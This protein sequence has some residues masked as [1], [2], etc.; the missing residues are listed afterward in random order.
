MG[1]GQGDFK[2]Q[3]QEGCHIQVAC[4]NPHMHPSQLCSVARAGKKEAEA[5]RPATL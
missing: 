5:E 2:I 4:Y 1:R 3:S